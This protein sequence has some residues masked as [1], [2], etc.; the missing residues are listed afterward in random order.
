MRSDQELTQPPRIV[1][2]DREATTRAL[3]AE[4]LDD[5][6]GRHYDVVIAASSDEGCTY[7]R[8]V[9]HAG[10]ALVLAD[11]AVDGARLLAAAWSLHPHAKRLLLIGWNEHRSAR[12]QIGELLR[13]GEADHYVAN[14]RHRPTSGSTARSASSSTIG[15]GLVV[16]RSPRSASSAMTT[17]Q[18]PTRSV[19][20]CTATT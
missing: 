19:T 11:R 8:E 14:R 2:V 20:C 5:R 17:R 7:L 9:A 3:L 15:G 16:V 13:H 12:E 4:E 18:G 1:A 6:Y 10:V